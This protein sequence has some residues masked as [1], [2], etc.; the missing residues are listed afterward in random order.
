MKLLVTGCQGQLGWELMRSLQPLG[1]VIGV[2]RR[3]CDLADPDSVIRMLRETQ[4]QGVVNA[5]AYT[6]VDKAESDPQA[7]AAVNS[8]APGVLAEQCRRLGALLV[9]YSTDYVFDGASA[10]PYR[11]D[12]PTAPLNEYGRS[13][14]AGE[15]AIRA[16]GDRYLILRTSWVYSLRGANFVRTIARLAQTRDTLRIVDDQLG[17]PTSAAWLADLTAQ[18]IGRESGRGPAPGSGLWHASCAGV[19][20]WH[21]FA[22]AILQTLAG[23]RAAR[24]EFMLDKRPQ[25]V[26][27]P[28]SEYP[29]PARRPANSRLA[30]DR[31]Q[32]DWGLHAP[33]WRAALQLVLRDA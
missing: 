27:I 3:Q 19:T 1:E 31:L 17:A 25:L 28:S 33:D 9:H 22:D 7:A 14:L 12:D 2:D 18:M 6:A 5:A 21:G 16:A 10:A 8:T 13:K 26:P 4:P 11:E 30:L 20:S 23:K 15:R 24:P 32:H 29:V